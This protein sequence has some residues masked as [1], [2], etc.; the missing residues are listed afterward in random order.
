[1]KDTLYSCLSAD[2]MIS[3]ED[4]PYRIDDFSDT[5]DRIFGVGARQLEILIMKKLHEKA[6]FSYHYEGPSWL[7]PNLTFSQYIELLRLSC[8]DT[9]KTGEI[10]VQVLDA[11]EKPKQRM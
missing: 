9:G 5:L 11:R 1:M 4:I 8:E 3:R 10:E 2:F 6:K 7:V